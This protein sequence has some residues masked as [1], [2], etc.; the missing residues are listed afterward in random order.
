MT[1][2]A[3]DQEPA[4]NERQL[5]EGEDEGGYACAVPAEVKQGKTVESEHRYTSYTLNQLT[6]KT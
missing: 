5:E 1:P 4:H 6:I 2:D 3:K